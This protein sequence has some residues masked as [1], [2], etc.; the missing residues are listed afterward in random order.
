MPRNEALVQGIGTLI[1]EA[2][3]QLPIFLLCTFSP[4]IFSESRPEA[5]SPCLLLFPCLP[6]NPTIP[7]PQTPN[8]PPPQNPHLPPPP[9]LL[10]RPTDS[11]RLSRPTRPGPREAQLLQRHELE[12]VAHDLPQAELRHL[13]SGSARGGPAAG[14]G[15]PRA[16]RERGG[17]DLLGS[18]AVGGI[19]TFRVGGGELRAAFRFCRAL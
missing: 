2:P 7:P 17:R 15:R 14:G 19:R 9:R 13:A 4:S 18:P 3:K 6:P 10:V 1:L 11:T 16:A 5:L 8:P 12:A